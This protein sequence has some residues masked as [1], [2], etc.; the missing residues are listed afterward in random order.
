M[1]LSLTVTPKISKNL[2][3]KILSLVRLSNANRAYKS[4]PSEMNQ[5]RLAAAVDTFKKHS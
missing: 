5:M 1:S 2:P 4:L 3:M